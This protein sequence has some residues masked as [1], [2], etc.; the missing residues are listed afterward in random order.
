[1]TNRTLEYLPVPNQ[2]TINRHDSGDV[3]VF[4]PMS[5]NVKKRAA[6]LCGCIFIFVFLVMLAGAKSLADVFG[7]TGLAIWIIA[8]MVTMAFDVVTCILMFRKKETII[9]ADAAGLRISK[10]G[11]KRVLTWER[12]KIRRIDV[13]PMGLL[14]NLVVHV[15]YDPKRV[16]VWH[17]RTD[18]QEA[19]AALSAVL[20]I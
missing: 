15:G 18:L 12:G 3:R 19:A 1:M 6:I 16:A 13:M 17:N 14:S 11:S 10:P 7:A 20:K 5:G 2:L 4:I 9:E 8:C